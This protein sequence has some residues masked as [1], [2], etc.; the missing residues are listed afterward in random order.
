MEEVY[1]TNKNKWIQLSLFVRRSDHQ[2]DT[3]KHS[4]LIRKSFIVFCEYCCTGRG[5]QGYSDLIRLPTSRELWEIGESFSHRRFRSF[6]PWVKKRGPNR[7]FQRFS[8]YVSGTVRLKSWIKNQ[9]YK[10]LHTNKFVEHRFV[11]APIENGFGVKIWGGSRLVTKD[12]T[13]F[14]SLFWTITSLFLEMYYKLHDRR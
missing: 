14:K 4:W 9:T 10:E 13:F 8:A 11:L 12:Q 1:P 7:V 2:P 5:R 3:S 6:Y